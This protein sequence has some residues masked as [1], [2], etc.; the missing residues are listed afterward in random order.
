MMKEIIRKMLIALC[1]AWLEHR[2][3]EPNGIETKETWY[4]YDKD[5]GIVKHAYG[6]NGRRIV[7]NIRVEGWRGMTP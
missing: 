5:M 1:L 6:L 3:D 7:V 2:E 4:V